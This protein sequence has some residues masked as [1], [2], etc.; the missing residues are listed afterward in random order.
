MVAYLVAE[1]SARAPVPIA[2]V[3]NIFLVSLDLEHTVPKNAI[4][5]TTAFT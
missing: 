5:D 1:Y 2:K 4:I 3:P